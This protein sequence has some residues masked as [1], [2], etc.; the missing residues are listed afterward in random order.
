MTTKTVK[1]ATKKAS[2]KVATKSKEVWIG[3][4]PDTPDVHLTGVFSSE[5]EVVEAYKNE[6]ANGDWSGPVVIAHI[7]RIIQDVQ[8][9]VKVEALDIK[10][11]FSVGGK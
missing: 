6:V 3:F 7:V 4:D 8:Q 9:P 2:E 5:A 10:K 1:K 11:F